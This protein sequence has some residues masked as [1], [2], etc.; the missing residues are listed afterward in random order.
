MVAGF[1]GFK[2]EILS[3]GDVAIETPA[4]LFVFSFVLTREIILHYSHIQYNEK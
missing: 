3:C 4:S 2:L 1:E